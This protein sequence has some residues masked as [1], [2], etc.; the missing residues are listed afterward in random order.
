MVRFI[1]VRHG[2]SVGNSEKRF[3]GQYDYKLSEIGYAQAEQTA[4]YITDNFKIDAIYSSDLL[5]AYDTAKPVADRLGLTITKRK[6][7]REV[8]VGFWQARLIEDVKKEFS[9][10]FNTYLNDVGLAEFDGGETYIDFMARIKF[11]FEKI[12]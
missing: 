6:E 9:K 1:I 8:D 12:A 3:S 11:V 5:R 4:K 2:Y 10:S 7:L